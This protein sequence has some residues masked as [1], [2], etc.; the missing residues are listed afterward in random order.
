MERI[1]LVTG[2]NRGI[3]FEIARQLG[4]KGIHV[5]VSGRNREKVEGVA[6]LM[7]KDDLKVT[8]LVLDVTD[9]ENIDR[10]FRFITDTFGRLDILVNNAAIFLSKDRNGLDTEASVIED[11]FNTNVI[12][13]FRIKQRAIPIMR[14]HHYG[15]I[16]N[17]SSRMGAINEMSGG[18][19]G[20]RISK[21]AL[22]AMTKILAAEVRGE[23]ILINSMCPG[24]VKTEMGGQNAPRTPEKG[25]ETAVWLAML[26]DNGPNGKFFRDHKEIKW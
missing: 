13:P 26:P 25:A 12:G 15:R 3:G 17:L 4:I 2:A 10:I 5:L 20:Y 24:W 14:R 18:Y 9:P 21:T 6:D 8:P 22:N 11:T 7:K 19:P 1:A 23:N 16:V